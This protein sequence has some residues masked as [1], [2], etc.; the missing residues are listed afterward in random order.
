MV[1]YERGKD[2]AALRLE[3]VAKKFGGLEA[4]R[5]VSLA[6]PRG[7]ITG[8]IGPNGAGKTTLFNIV[9]GVVK[10][11][12]GRMTV[13][14]LDVTG[15]RPDELARLGISRTFQNVRLFR[16]MNVLENVLSGSIG[17]KAPGWTDLARLRRD[18]REID[19]L[20]G[21]ARDLL[22]RV[23]LEDLG[24]VMAGSLPYGKQRRVEIARALAAKPRIV[25]LDE[26]S[27]GMSPEE[28]EDVTR[29]V[30]S[31]R[32]EGLTIVLIEHN[33]RLVMDLCDKVAVLN[34]GAKIAEG[35]AA[36]VAS[37]PAVVTAYLGAA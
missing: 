3:L 1:G 36:D 29:I 31:L 22:S 32:A 25:L 10:P 5:G 24:P 9:T 2:E 4:L 37:D 27:A 33:M 13:G 35:T 19:R 7:G 15:R 20:T 34:F 23:G 18:R 14:E 6:V 11:T 21:E 8:I 17:R 12:S 16:R 28:A 26:P 30:E